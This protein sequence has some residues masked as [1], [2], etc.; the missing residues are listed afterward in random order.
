[1]SNIGIKTSETLRGASKYNSETT[2]PSFVKW[3][4]KSAATL[5]M[6]TGFLKAVS[7]FLRSRFLELQDP[8]FGVHFKNLVLFV[9][10]LEFAVVLICAS[11]KP[12]VIKILLVGWLGSAF[13]IY[14]IGL[15]L[16]GWSAP[17]P[18]LG[19]F[20]EILALPPGVVDISMV[21]I[22]IYLIG[23]SGLSVYLLHRNP[24]S[25][26]ASIRA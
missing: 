26:M 5:L 14:R 24:N 8:I 10:L 16:V 25:S 1:M 18:C 12:E 13:L 7:F 21:L 4:L 20:V 3:F 6:A 2:V 23:G 11:S 9:A 15:F 17:C 19:A 22:G